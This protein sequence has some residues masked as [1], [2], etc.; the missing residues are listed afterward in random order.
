LQIQLVNRNLYLNL[1]TESKAR[2]WEN[3]D[4]HQRGSDQT[5]TSS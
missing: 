3:V 1:G 2:L 4:A 5:S